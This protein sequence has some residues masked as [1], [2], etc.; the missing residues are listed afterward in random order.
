LAKLQIPKSKYQ[1]NAKVQNLNTNVVRPFRV[2]PPFALHEAEASHYI[3]VFRTVVSPPK[4]RGIKGVISTI[5]VT[6][7]DFIPTLS[8]KVGTNPFKMQK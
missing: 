4:V 3:F 5:F 7:A 8:G 2:V 1:I 6:P